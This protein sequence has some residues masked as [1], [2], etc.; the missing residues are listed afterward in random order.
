MADIRTYQ[1]KHHLSG[2]C[3]LVCPNCF[4]LLN[5]DDIEHFSVCPYCNARLEVNRQLENF[6]LQPVVNHWLAH[7]LPV[8]PFFV[9][10]PFGRGGD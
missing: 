3:R 9:D 1:F 5:R 6:L 7:Q 8:S 4:E 10:A 2:D